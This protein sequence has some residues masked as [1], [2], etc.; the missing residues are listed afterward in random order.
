MLQ[1]R[2][3]VERESVRQ[4]AAASSSAADG[5]QQQQQGITSSTGSLDIKELPWEDRERILRLLFAKI[6]NQAQQAYY[7]NLPIHPLEPQ[8][9]EEGGMY[10]GAV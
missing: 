9:D 7:T 5:G 3:E 6:N 2:R 10:G 1:V 4:A 8:E